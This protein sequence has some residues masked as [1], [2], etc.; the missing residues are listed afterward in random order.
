MSSYNAIHPQ[1]RLVIIPMNILQGVRTSF[2]GWL[3][4]LRAAWFLTVP[5][6]DRELF[7]QQI[8]YTNITR[9]RIIAW[10][11]IIT[12]L[13]LIGIHLVYIS[14]VESQQIL[15]R[16]PQLIVLRLILITISATFLVLAGRQQSPNSITP[17]H[18][19]Y[20]LYYI[21]ANLICIA[22]L[23]GIV[24]AIASGIA[25][26]YLMA[27]MVI[28]AF[29][30]LSL[31]ESLL[32]FGVAWVSVSVAVWLQPNWLVASSA[33]LNC[34][35]VTIIA[36]VITR[37]NY[38]LKVKE[39]I[40]VKLIETQKEELT[41]SNNMLRRLSYLD[42][43]TSVPN[44]R[45]F[46]EYFSREWSRALRDR[47]PLS[48]L[49]V[50]ID[51]FKLYNDT[52]GHQAGDQCLAQVAAALSG[53]LRRT[54][55]FVARYGGEEF[56]VILPGA[57]QAGAGQVAD[58]M[59]RAVAGLNILHPGGSSGRLTISIGMA[60]IIPS[61]QDRIEQLIANADAGLY[62]AKREGGNRCAR[63]TVRA[64]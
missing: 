43:L 7:Q 48:L 36:L 47:R 39:F 55:D 33:F 25:S 49:M 46:D 53:A 27:V 31:K 40:N 10:L 28:A 13:V 35:I 21:L 26:S 32:I 62:R 63:V 1:Q 23:T 24:Q 51:Q 34:T 57:G 61:E 15:D 12:N 22:L 4:V 52:Y 45:Y 41:Q 19:W 8:T 54:G 38:D 60:T 58:R 20:A 14:Q 2:T 17:E 64:G 50:D 42:A 6:D 59:R 16:T 56:T 29:V 37:V 9:L 3:N 5:P 11:I 30:H 18:S 44:R